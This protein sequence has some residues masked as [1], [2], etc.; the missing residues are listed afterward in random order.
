[1]SDHRR[2]QTGMRIQIALVNSHS[3]E[4]SPF[5]MRKSTISMAVFNSKVLV[6]TGGHPALS[7]ILLAASSQLAAKLQLQEMKWD[8]PGPC[9]LTLQLQS[10][11]SHV[12]ICGERL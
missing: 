6:I 12:R 2:G 3:Y 5:S 11:M 4:K 1:M 7:N 8:K 10:G 9:A